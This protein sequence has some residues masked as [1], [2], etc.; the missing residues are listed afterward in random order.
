MSG[1]TIAVDFD[2]TVTE[3][4]LLD[5]IARDFGD[6][7]VYQAELAPHMWYGPVAHTASVHCASACRNFFLQEWDGASDPLF[8]EVTGGTCPLQKAGVVSLPQG[9]GLGITVDFDLLKRRLP[10]ATRS[11]PSA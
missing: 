9:P 8:Q 1:R 5:T 3:I 11:R 6:P 10:Y 2:G 7:E 4:D